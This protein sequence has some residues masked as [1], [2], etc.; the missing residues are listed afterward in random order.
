MSTEKLDSLI[1]R[2]LSDLDAAA[3]RLQYDIQARI[4]KEI[5]VMAESWAEEHSWEGKFNFDKDELRIAPREWKLPDAKSDDPWLGWF[6]LQPSLGD[7][8]DSEDS[9]EFLD[10]FWLTRLCGAG[11]GMIGFR[12]HYGVGV[13]APK[14]K[15]KKFAQAHVQRIGKAGFT[16]EES[17]LFFKPVRVETEKVAAAVG[18]E[19]AVEVALAP[20]REAL[21]Q[22]L[23]AKPEF[24]AM[25]KSA[26]KF[27]AA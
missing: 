7:D 20:V 10:Y 9:K 11:R 1:V 21:G 17:G 26:K 16:Y 22:L 14:L 18:E 2:N 25:L 27:F 3:M 6:S 4:G 5:D 12:W 8:W 19:I 24:D 13:G 23:V 15:W